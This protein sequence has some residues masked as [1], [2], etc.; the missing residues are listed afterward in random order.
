MKLRIFL[1][2]LAL[3]LVPAA[4]GAIGVGVGAFGGMSYPVLQDN[5]GTG[6]QFGLRVPFTLAPLVTVEGYYASSALGDV[7]ETIAGQTY[8]RS[9]PD[10]T[11]YGLNGILNFGGA[12]R[13]YP[14]AGFGSS[15]I[16]Q[17]ST[18][19]LTETNFNFGVGFGFTLMPKLSLDLRGELNSVLTGDTSRKFG[20]LTVG[21][22]YALFNN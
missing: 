11:T 17:A 13:F 4:A 7:D 16:K 9:G 21:V 20:N 14:F 5:A 3:A 22:S 2:A 6:S 8:T 10:V 15:T 19:D 1:G 18:E 12:Y